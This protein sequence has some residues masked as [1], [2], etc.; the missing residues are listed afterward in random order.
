ML[1]IT[2]KQSTQN[3]V[4]IMYFKKFVEKIKFLKCQIYSFLFQFYQ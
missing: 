3:K 1:R 2:L 4:I